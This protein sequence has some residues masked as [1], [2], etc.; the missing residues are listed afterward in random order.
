MVQLLEPVLLQVTEVEDPEKNSVRVSVLLVGQGVIILVQTFMRELETVRVLEL[1]LPV[2]VLVLL[3][4]ERPV[5]VQL[6]DLVLDLVVLFPKVSNKPSTVLSKTTFIEE[7]CLI[8][9][10]I[11]LSF[12]SNVCFCANSAPVADPKEL[13]TGGKHSL[14]F[15]ESTGKYV[16]RHEMNDQ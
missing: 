1:A 14:V 2:Q 3:V 11:P 7:V 15:Q 5:M 9:I 13:D 10:L 8:F 16:H 4:L 6:L 12:C